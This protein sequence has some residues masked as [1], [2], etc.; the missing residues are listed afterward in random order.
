MP[1]E[2]LEHVLSILHDAIERQLPRNCADTGLADDIV[3][4]PKTAS[5]ELNVGRTWAR[6][7]VRR[8]GL[9]RMRELDMGKNVFA[10]I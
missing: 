3:Q 8:A 5:S 6:I 7:A 2:A 1:L 9:R 10:P 4:R